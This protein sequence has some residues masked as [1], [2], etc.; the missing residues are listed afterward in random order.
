MPSPAGSILADSD[1]TIGRYPQIPMTRMRSEQMSCLFDLPYTNT[2]VG[3]VF[4]HDYWW[5]RQPVEDS[6]LPE[7]SSERFH[8]FQ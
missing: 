7:P 8:L 3:S 4:P 1:L 6:G 5:H 2:M